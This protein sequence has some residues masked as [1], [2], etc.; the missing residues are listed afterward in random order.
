MKQSGD[1]NHDDFK[2]ELYKWRDA[3]IQHRPERLFVDSREMLFTIVP[4]IQEWFVT[5]I[6]TLSCEPVEAYR[7]DVV[8]VPSDVYI[9]F[10]DVVAGKIPLAG[11]PLEAGVDDDP[12]PPNIPN[13]SITLYVLFILYPFFRA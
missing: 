3:I 13:G 8:F 7:V 12:P 9:P 10:N 5:D 1:L 6:F 4:E 2:Q 11:K